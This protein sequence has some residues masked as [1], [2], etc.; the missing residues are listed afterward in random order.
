M[1]MYKRVV[2]PAEA[3]LERVARMV[4]RWAG[5]GQVGWNA[6]DASDATGAANE[7]C[8]EVLM[9]RMPGGRKRHQGWTAWRAR[10]A[11]VKG[12]RQKN[13]GSLGTKGPAN[14]SLQR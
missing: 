5:T 11:V 7:G 3:C 2:S 4:G 8:K 12:Q 14:C 10:N 9:K 1:C 6:N 13:K